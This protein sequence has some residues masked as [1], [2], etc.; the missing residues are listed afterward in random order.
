MSRLSPSLRQLF[1]QSML[2][3][4]LSDDASCSVV[5]KCA[6]LIGWWQRSGWPL[7]L[8]RPSSGLSGAQRKQWRSLPHTDRLAFDFSYW[9]SQDLRDLLTESGAASVTLPGSDLDGELLKIAFIANE[10]RIPT[11]VISDAV[12]VSARARYRN[13][14]SNEAVLWTLAS[15]AL[16]LPMAEFVPAVESAI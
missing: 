4:S 5:C 13:G 1:P 16:L 2:L 7:A 12:E 6:V 15:T 14:Q 10:E 8:L 3:A 11:M 9:W